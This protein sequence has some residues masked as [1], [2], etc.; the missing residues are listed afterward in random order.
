MNNFT[1]KLE[2]SAGYCNDRT[3]FTDKSGILD[4]ST[5]P[6]YADTSS[7][8]T[9]YFGSYTRVSD[10]TYASINRPSLNCPRSTVDLYRYVAGSTGVSNQLK[11]P[12]AL[13]TADEATFAGSGYNS[14]TTPYHANSFLRSGSD[15]WLLSPR[16]RSKLGSTW[17]FDLYSDGNLGTGLVNDAL[18][19]RPAISLTPGTMAAS[20]TGTATDPWI[21]NP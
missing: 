17:H 16:G 2:A 15:F 21:V 7:G 5:I 20:G 3:A 1:S 18:G 9:M 12:V 10:T 4:M 11:Y 6:P 14:L 8:A 13:I 19:V